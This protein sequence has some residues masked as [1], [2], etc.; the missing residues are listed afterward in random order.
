MSETPEETDAVEE[1]DEPAEEVGRRELRKLWRWSWPTWGGWRYSPSSDPPSGGP[2]LRDA[3][4]GE[5]DA[6]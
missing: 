2:G 1:S 5:D 4:E 6:S 3:L